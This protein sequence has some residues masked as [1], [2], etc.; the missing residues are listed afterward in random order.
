MDSPPIENGA[1]LIREGEVVEVGP[2]RHLRT[3]G[4]GTLEDLG[5]VIVLP[6]LINAHA[7]LDYTGMAGQLPSPVQ[8][9]DWIK[10]MLALKAE[11][12]QADYAAD[13]VRGAAMLLQSGTTTVVDIEAVPELLPGIWS[14]T[15]LRVVS[16]LEL[17]GVRSGREPESLVQEAA[18]RIDSFPPGRSQGGL[19]PHAPYST[20]PALLRLSAE[21]SRSRD[22]VLTTHVAE[23]EAEFEMFTEAR[24]PLYD[25]LRWNGRDMSDCGR[26]SPVEHLAELEVLSSKFLP[27]HLNYLAPGD[28]RLLNASG[29]TVVHCPRSHTYFGHARFPYE[30]LRQEGVRI[31]LGTDSLASIQCSTQHPARLDLFAEMR[32]FAQCRPEVAPLE[33]L[34]MVTQYGAEALGR[35]DSLG[36]LGVGSR[37][38]LVVLASKPGAA[39]LAEAVLAHE[40]NVHGVMI[41]G[42]WV[43]GQSGLRN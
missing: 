7:H 21:L 10:G 29:A 32:A 30:S 40:G 11:R 22:W 6:G 26:Y 2:W 18:R 12:S 4:E 20:R 9:P 38:D 24:G 35:A 17:T 16:C 15:P 39:E 37:A 28:A 3:R 43:R 19:S 13:W 1:L 25:W 5:E 34:R 23:S 31:A 8:F 41:E 14:V 42:S 36:R 27:V 33:I